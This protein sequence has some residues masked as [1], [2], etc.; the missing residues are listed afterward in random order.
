MPRPGQFQRVVI[1]TSG[2]FPLTVLHE[3]LGEAQRGRLFFYGTAELT[4]HAALIRKRLSPGGV[5]LRN[6]LFDEDRARPE[7][8][9]AQLAE[10]TADLAAVFPHVRSR[11]FRRWDNAFALA[12]DTK[13]TRKAMRK[14]G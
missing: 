2:F 14:L 10:Q 8:K 6:L 3:V 5:Y 7:D 9:T 4:R 1:D 13:I 11:R 12:S